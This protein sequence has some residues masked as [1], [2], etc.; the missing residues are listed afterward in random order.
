MVITKRILSQLYG[1][2]DFSSLSGS[3]LARKAALCRDL[4]ATVSKADP[5][6]SSFRGLTSWELYR[7]TAALNKSRVQQ[8]EAELK[9]EQAEEKTLLLTIIL[10]LQME[11]KT[12]MAWKIAERCKKELSLLDPTADPSSPTT[13]ATIYQAITRTDRPRVFMELSAGG[14]SLGRL[15][16]ELRGD[17]VPRT[18]D[19]F[20]Q[21]CTGEKGFGYK[22]STFHR[23]IPGF[24][25]QGGDYTR[26]DGTGGRSVYGE[27]FADENFSLKHTGPGE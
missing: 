3:E 19:N 12:S 2:T 11:N 15:V 21:L 14:E 4:L 20:R 25:A 8:V 23:I 26:G 18:V 7:A 5:G 9:K 17:V 13:M 10:C 1:Q 27:T 24:M 16:M 6:F 22:D